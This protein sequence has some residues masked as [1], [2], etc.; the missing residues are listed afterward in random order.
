M[1][2][3]SRQ[4]PQLGDGFIFAHAIVKVI[5]R[6]TCGVEFCHNITG[7]NRRSPA[8]RRV[9]PSDQRF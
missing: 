9:V 1:R 7:L 3:R 6:S 2:K 8:L 4:T 5:V